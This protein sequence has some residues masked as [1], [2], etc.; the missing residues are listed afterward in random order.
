MVDRGIERSTAIAT[1]NRQKRRGYICQRRVL[2]L[3]HHF[4]HPRKLTEIEIT[5]K[6]T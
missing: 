5:T 2:V 4:Y 3:G 1:I 6:A